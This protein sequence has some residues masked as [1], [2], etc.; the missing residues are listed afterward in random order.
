MHSTDINHRPIRSWTKITTTVPKHLADTMSTFLGGLTESGVEFKANFTPTK[1]QPIES[2]S[3]YLDNDGKLEQKIAKIQVFLDDLAKRYPQHPMTSIQTEQ[4]IEEDWGSR[5]K[6]HFKPVQI[7]DR[8]IIKPSWESLA[9]ENKLLFIELDP[10]MAFGTGLHA[11]T[12]LSLKL[13]DQLYLPNSSGPTSTLDIGTGTGMSCALLGCPSVI[14]ID[15]DIDARVAAE[16]NIS[17]NKLN[18]KMKIIDSDL[19]EISDTF[20]LVI[21]NII[22]NTLVN[23][24]DQIVDR[25]GKQGYLIMAGILSGQQIDNIITVY[26]NLGLELIKT[27]DQDEW[28]AVCLRRL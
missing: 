16:A 4:I 24:A 21:A 20:A 18:T 23:L 12:Q 17:R 8:L 3:I 27:V 22:H 11:S 9:P 6:K 2:I 25:V 26:R 28:S 1:N 7:T 13:I 10:G 5:W 14:G 15:N 19:A